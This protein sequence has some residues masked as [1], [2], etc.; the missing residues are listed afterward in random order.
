MEAGNHLPFSAPVGERLNGVNPY[1]LE[2]GNDLYAE[3]GKTM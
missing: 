1:V 2:T 3:V